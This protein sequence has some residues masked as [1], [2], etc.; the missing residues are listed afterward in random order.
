MKFVFLSRTRLWGHCVP[1]GSLTGFILASKI[2][3][4]LILETCPFFHFF[5][6]DLFFLKFFFFTCITIQFVTNIGI[7]AI[8]ERSSKEPTKKQKHDKDNNAKRKSLT[9]AQKAEICRLKQKGVS[10]VKLAENFGIAEATISG[11]IRGK[12]KWLSLNLSSNNATLKRQRT[13]KFPLLEEALALWVS[14][15]NTALQTVTGVILQRKAIQLA[16]RLDVKVSMPLMG[17]FQNS[18]N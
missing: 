15:A 13:G 4:F 16:E 9:G 8:V 5:F 6:P 17:G 18:K 14:R 11:I 3:L 10:Q 7:M 2:V 12:E 1:N